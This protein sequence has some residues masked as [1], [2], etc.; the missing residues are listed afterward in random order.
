MS[1]S[2]AADLEVQA[3]GAEEGLVT[4]ARWKVVL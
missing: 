2:T 4:V 1:N 3:D